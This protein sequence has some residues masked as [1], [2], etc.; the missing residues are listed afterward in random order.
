MNKKT[1]YEIYQDGY[2]EYVTY[3]VSNKNEKETIDWFMDDQGFKENDF[4]VKKLSDE[5]VNKLK[6]YN[7]DEWYDIDELTQRQIETI[8]L[9][10]NA[11]IDESN[12]YVILSEGKKIFDM[13]QKDIFICAR[14]QAFF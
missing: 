11:K 4:V 12:G 8:E 14:S 2:D 3:V 6:V 1:I 9:K 10:E 5:E 7:M 13:Y